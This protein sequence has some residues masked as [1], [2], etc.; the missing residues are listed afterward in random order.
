M[1]KKIT[2]PLRY[3]LGFLFIGLLLVYAQYL[4]TYQGVTPCPLCLVQRLVFGILAIVFLLGITAS[5][6]RFGQISAGILSILASLLGILV[7]GRQVWLQHLPPETAG[8]CEAG[9]EYMLSALPIDQVLQKL[10]EGSTACSQIGWELFH[11]SLA[12]WSLVSFIFFL[13]FSIWQLRKQA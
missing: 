10:Y 12:E 9:L 11:L 8:N 6:H 13:L 2:I 7:S 5:K 3:L 1:N 4:Q